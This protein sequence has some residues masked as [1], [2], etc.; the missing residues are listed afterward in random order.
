MTRELRA[1]ALKKAAEM[2]RSGFPEVAAKLRGDLEKNLAAMAEARR[3]AARAQAQVAVDA[4]RQMAKT[5][6]VA[7][8]LADRVR[9]QLAALSPAERRAPA[10]EG[11]SGAKPT[12]LVP[13]DAP[14][15]DAIVQVNPDFFDASLPPTAV[16]H[17]VVIT[18]KAELGGE[19]K[20]LHEW[21]IKLFHELDY[22][23][24]YALLK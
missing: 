17:I 21:R 3:T 10:C 19:G 5:R 4:P 11:T 1:D 16:Q 14:G 20:G 15:A 23:G 8:D 13:C 6:K 9:A 18:K 12:Y 22:P 7:D 2:E 24:L